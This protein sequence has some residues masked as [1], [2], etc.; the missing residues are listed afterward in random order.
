MKLIIDIPDPTKEEKEAGFNVASKFIDDIN[1]EIQ[2]N[3]DKY[4][5]SQFNWEDGDNFI[6]ALFVIA[7]KQNDTCQW[8]LEDEDYNMWQSG[9]GGQYQFNHDGPIENNH[10]FCHVCGKKLEINI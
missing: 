5:Y 10:K 9:C 1:D 7:E 3:Q 6:M 4:C 2:N 8:S